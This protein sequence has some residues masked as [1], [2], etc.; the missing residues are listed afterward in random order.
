MSRKQFYAV[1]IIGYDNAFY[2]VEV[3][4][5]NRHVGEM[6]KVLGASKAGYVAAF[7]HDLG[8]IGNLEKA[9][10]SRKPQTPEDYLEAYVDWIIKRAA[11]P[12]NLNSSKKNSFVMAL[13]KRPRQDRIKAIKSVLDGEISDD[14]LQTLAGFS[15]SPFPRHADGIPEIVQG[16]SVREEYLPGAGCPPELTDYAFELIRLHHSFRVDRIV[17]AA[18]ALEAHSSV[19]SAQ[20]FVQDLHTLISADNV[21]SSLYEKALSATDRTFSFGDPAQETFLLHDLEG[22][23]K[24]E[25]LSSSGKLC[26]Q[27]HLEWQAA[28]GHNKGLDLVITYHRVE[29]S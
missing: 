9:I 14:C 19:A 28:N 7:C 20:Q 4:D 8:K 16:R 3:Y 25:W 17:E 12:K 1:K 18:S 29:V 6:A 21:I 24:I 10:A 15:I 11:L 26:C 22:I 5:H 23:G 2:L 13:H 27:V